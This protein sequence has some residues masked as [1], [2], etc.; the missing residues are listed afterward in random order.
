MYLPLSASMPTSHLGLFTA[1]CLSP[2]PPL[3]QGHTP[4][5]GIEESFR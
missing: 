2:G 4:S 3:M 1:Y 5:G